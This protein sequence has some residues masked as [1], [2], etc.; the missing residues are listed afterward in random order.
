M[1]VGERTITIKCPC[2]GRRLFDMRTD[3]QGAISIKCSRCK[4]VMAV[5]MM[6]K[7]RI[8]VVPSK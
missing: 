4:T 6:G 3:T 2:C 7:N 8:R 5:R 1:E